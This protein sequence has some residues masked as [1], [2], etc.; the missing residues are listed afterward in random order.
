MFDDLRSG[1][2]WTNDLAG[3][4]GSV[5]EERP[6]SSCKVLCR[7]SGIGTATCLWIL[8]DKAGLKIPSLLGAACSIDRSEELK[9]VLFETLLLLTTLTEQ[10]AS[11]FQQI[12]NEYESCF[13]FDY[14]RDS[15]RTA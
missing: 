1:R 13:L 3:A 7:P 15:F 11:G 5:L 2:P 6:F 8:R 14:P 4:I 9:S 12:I 10:K